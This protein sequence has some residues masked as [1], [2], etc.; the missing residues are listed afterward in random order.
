MQSFF[1]PNYSV[2]TFLFFK[3]FVFF[4]ILLLLS[5][6][7]IFTSQAKA[8]LVSFIVFLLSSWALITLF[9]PSLGWYGLPLGRQTAL[10]LGL[11]NGMLAPV[12]LSL[13]FATTAVLPKVKRRTIN[14]LHI[15]LVLALFA[16]WGATFVDW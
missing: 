9:A 10:L 7:R 6:F 13:I 15:A 8:R 11:Q 5:L 2:L 4:Q 14:W 16:T 3:K 1:E 12:G